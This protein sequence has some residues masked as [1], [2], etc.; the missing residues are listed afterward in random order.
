MRIVSSVKKNNIKSYAKK[1]VTSV[2][3]KYLVIKEPLENE[4]L[5]ARNNLLFH[6]DDSTQMQL[7]VNNAKTRD[8]YVLLNLN[9]HTVCQTGQTNWNSITRLDENAWKKVSP[10]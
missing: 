5:Y 8:F 2:I 3:P 9:I 10:P 4:L 7:P 1:K 6:L